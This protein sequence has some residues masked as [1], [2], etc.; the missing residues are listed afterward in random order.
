M[1]RPASLAFWFDFASTY[2]YPAA[3]RVED[4]TRAAGVSLDYRPFLLGPIFQSQGWND[5]PFN[6]YPVKGAYMWR[7]LE[8][9]CAGLGLPFRR[10]S[11]FP[12]NSVRAAR[13]AVTGMNEPWCGRFVRATFEA[14]F[15]EDRDIADPE[16]IVRI[17]EAIGMP[18]QVILE[19]AESSEHKPKLRVQSEQ[20]ARA[21]IF[22]APTFVVSGEMFWGND[23]LEEAVA[24]AL[25]AAKV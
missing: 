11:V 21:G 7:D 2:S 3:A 20:A 18:G 4:V 5:S 22:G 23:R 9:T 25:R 24:W 1:G 16:E 14:N 12:R 17:L 13:V 19:H 8:R 15:G 6:L 10:P